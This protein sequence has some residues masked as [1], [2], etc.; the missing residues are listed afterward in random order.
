MASAMKT[1]WSERLA[2]NL[3]WIGWCGKTSGQGDVY[4]GGRRRTPLGEQ[5]AQ[6]D[7]RE[8]GQTL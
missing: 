6:E 7:P 3:L 5:K 1:K 4:A 2:V 8:K